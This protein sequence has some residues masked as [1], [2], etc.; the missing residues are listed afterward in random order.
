[1]KCFYILIQLSLTII[2]IDGHGFLAD[3]PPRGANPNALLKDRLK[4]N[5]T[6]EAFGYDTSRH[7]RFQMMRHYYGGNFWFT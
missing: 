5:V 6:Y 1:M 2:V 4:N 3:P 7:S